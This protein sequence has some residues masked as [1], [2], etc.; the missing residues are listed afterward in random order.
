MRHLLTSLILLALCA[1]VPALA[2]AEVDRFL[3]RGYVYDEDYDP[4]DSVEVNLVRA[5]TAA[6]SFRLLTGVDSL[7]LLTGNAQLRMLVDGGLGAYQLILYKDGY[8]PLVHDFKITAASQTVEYLGSLRMQRERH[9]ELGEVTVTATRVKMVVKGDT[10]VFD[11]AAFNLSEGSMLDALVSQLPGA[12]LSADGVIE[13]NGRRINELLV[14][15]KDFFKGD[16]KVALQNLPAYTVKSL[17]VYAKPDDDDYLTRRSATVDRR[18]DQENLVMNVVLKKEYDTGWLANAEAGYGTEGRYKGRLFAMGYTEKL[19]IGAY[20]NLNNVGN[21]SSAGDSGQWDDDQQESGRLKVAMAGLDYNYNDSKRIEAS[22]N[23]TWE[24][25]DHSETSMVSRTRFFPEADLYS[26]ST[27]ERSSLTTDVATSHR[28]QY[29]GDNLYAY[30]S[31]SVKRERRTARTRSRTATF[32]SLPDETHRGEAVDSVF[33]PGGATSAFARTLLTRLQQLSVTDPVD[34]SCRL[35]MGATLRPASW[36][37]SLGFSAGGRWGR[38]TYHTHTLYDQG[39]GPGADGEQSPV[40]RDSYRANRADDHALSAAASYNQ[41]IRRFGEQR[42]STFS[43][44]ARTGMNHNYSNTDVGAWAADSLPPMI[45]PPSVARPEYLLADLENSPYTRRHDTRL[46]ATA[47]LSF[48][49]E[50]TAP[51]DSAFNAAFSVSITGSY[52]HER[53]SYLFEKPGITRQD[54]RRNTDFVNPTLNLQLNS[55]NARR[56]LGIYLG[57]SFSQSA[58]P[59]SYLIDNRNSSDPLN[60]VLGNPGGLRNASVHNAYL[61]FNRFPRG[62]GTTITG[63]ASLNVTTDQV[64]YAQRYNPATGVTISRPENISGNWS[65][66]LSGSAFHSFGKRKQLTVE[67]SMEVDMLNSV[68]Y[69][70]MDS[71]PERSTVFNVGYSPSVSVTYTFANGSEIEGVFVTKIDRQQSRRDDF[72]NS[73]TLTYAPRLRVMLKLPAGIELNSRLQP[74][75]RRGFTDRSMNTSQ[76]VWNATVLRTFG[77]SGLTL[78]LSAYDLLG[79]AKSLSSSVNAQGRTETWRNTLPRYVMLS[80]IYRFD[81]KPRGKRPRE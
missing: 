34:L 46:T 8:E 77:S 41:Q 17:K 61:F 50:P 5:D 39:Y 63:S 28:L 37:G 57:Y 48:G 65:A 44:S 56:F 59:L 19:R 18:D 70:A 67:T 45:V 81:L 68:D 3:L 60:I 40:R 21:Q 24:H 2:R 53:E 38:S 12:T 29:K 79:S 76:W 66:T 4:I 30:I 78:K 35:D 6:V 26:R 10:L 55:S 13:V 22:G 71:E 23:L 51:A 74:Y 47:T 33:G 36:K 20:A 31:P 14:N 80:A 27:Q 62:S 9:R 64:G 32:G 52:V 7:R 72:D 75:F 25:A 54:L 43:I 73:T 11:A 42:T 69:V 16:P 58:P 1:S 49:I 15:G